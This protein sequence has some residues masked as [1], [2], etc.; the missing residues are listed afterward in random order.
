MDKNTRLPQNIVILGGGF[1]GIAC[2]RELAKLL[3][4]HDL[5][6]QFIPVLIDRQAGQLYQPALYEIASTTQ[7]D[8][9]AYELQKVS[10]VSY[11]EILAGTG[12]RFLQ[13]EVTAIDSAERLVQT[14]S[15][16]LLPFA[17]LILALGAEPNF[18]G[19]AG[20][21]EHV[22]SFRSFREI[23]RL[24]NRIAERLAAQ[25]RLPI[26]V[27]G[28]GSAGVEVAA[29][30]MG[31]GRALGWE[32]PGVVLIEAC[33]TILKG[34]RPDVI[35]AA[36]RRLETIGVTIKTGTCVTSA[37]QAGLMVETAPGITERIETLVT[38]WTGGIQ[39]NR[40]AQAAALKHD[41]SGHMAV[42]ETLLC[43]SGIWAIG[44]NTHLIDPET[45]QPVPAT[46]RVAIEQGKHAARNIVRRLMGKSATPYRIR[47]YPYVIPIGGK[48]AIAD[49]LI[50]RLTG[51]AGWCIK[52]AIELVYLS[53]I[54][55][56]SRAVMIWLRG[57]SIYIQ[58][59]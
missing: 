52:Q 19:I 8:A 56:F 1:G 58:N 26:A 44:D 23:I 17:H 47:R 15:E 43:A 16:P 39:P 20:L 46:A 53:S 7:A 18:F 2:A 36:T 33:P 6:R 12:V 41:R 9:S 29:E 27:C 22:F 32:K 5:A 50:F 11:E 30:M 42:S 54:L 51:F 37:D 49:L 55:P 13:T 21:E 34:F 24:R 38:I 35:R 59:D 31:F 3:K 40:L 45:K 48:W 25:T 57:L 10:V 14:T 28:G 4:Q